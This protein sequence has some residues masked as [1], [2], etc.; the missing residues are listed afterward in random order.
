MQVQDNY[1]DQS[2]SKFL[3]FTIAN[4]NDNYPVSSDIGSFK[5]NSKGLYNMSGNVSEWVNDYYDIRPNRGEPEID[6]TGPT[7]GNRHVIR[8]AS[9]ALGSRTEL[10]LSYRDA[11]TEGRLDVGFRIAR[12]V[13]RPGAKP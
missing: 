3:S 4:Y 12:Y 2:A 11:G 1:A 7:S 6:P 5:P 10:R 8:G 9:W 13:D